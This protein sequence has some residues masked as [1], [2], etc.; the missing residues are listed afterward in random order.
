MYRQVKGP[1]GTSAW[2]A[3][4]LLAGTPMSLA[5]PGDALA[6]PDLDTFFNTKPHRGRTGSW[7]APQLAGTYVIYYP[8]TTGHPCLV[9]TFLADRSLQATPFD[10]EEEA[11]DSITNT[12]GWPK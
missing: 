9:V 2:A 4:R 1:S 11:V 6:D 10:D 12:S 5:R 3:L 8:P 7:Q